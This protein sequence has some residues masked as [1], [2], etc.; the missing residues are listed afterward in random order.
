MT[1]MLGLMP[2]L[3]VAIGSTANGNKRCRRKAKRF[4]FAAKTMG[5]LDGGIEV[6]TRPILLI[7]LSETGV[8]FSCKYC[9]ENG[10]Q[11]ELILAGEMTGKT[12]C[13]NATVAHAT[14]GQDGRWIVGCAFAERLS[15]A[16]VQDLL[17]VNT[18]S[19]ARN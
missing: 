17:G 19:N 16:S 8:G 4:A 5:W 11:L 2:F 10:T 13:V 12:L 3:R 7:D 15:P 18:T 6:S 1:P 9:I 14:K